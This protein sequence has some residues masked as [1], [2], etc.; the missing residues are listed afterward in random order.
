MA[1]IYLKFINKEGVLIQLEGEII[2]STYCDLD[3]VLNTRQDSIA[4][5]CKNQ[6]FVIGDDFPKVYKIKGINEYPS[7]VMKKSKNINYDCILIN[8]YED[9]IQES[10]DIKNRIADNGTKLKRYA[11]STN[12]TD[13]LYTHGYTEPE[14]VTRHNRPITTY[15]NT[16]PDGNISD[17]IRIAMELTHAPH[18]W[19]S[20]LQQLAIYN[21]GNPKDANI[22]LSKGVMQLTEDVFKENMIEGHNNILNP[23]D[24]IASAIIYIIRRYGDI[25]NVP[26]I[27][28]IINSQISKIKIGCNVW[29]EEIVILDVNNIGTVKNKPISPTNDTNIFGWAKINNEQVKID[30]INK[31]FKLNNTNPSNKKVKVYYYYYDSNAQCTIVSANDLF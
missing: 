9:T 19:F 3:I 6:R 18:D 2:T 13:T 23:I 5:L 8:L 27:K 7:D 20:Y 10:D 16:I 26:G 15:A 22:R 28:D 24:N 14:H 17:W 30:F 1:E 29:K 11:T 25:R 31:S 12:V 4:G 21:P